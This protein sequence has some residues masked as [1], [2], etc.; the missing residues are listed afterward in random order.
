[1]ELQETV[2]FNDTFINH[3]RG[4]IYL[5]YINVLHKSNEEI[6]ASRGSLTLFKAVIQH[7]SNNV[8]FPIKLKNEPLFR[9]ISTF[10]EM[11]TVVF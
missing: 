4:R 7:L 11:M 2:R 8:L 6:K 1:M 10:L 9:H 5:R 3:R